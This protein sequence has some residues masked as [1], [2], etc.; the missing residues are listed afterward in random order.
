MKDIEFR[1]YDKKTKQ[2]VTEENVYKIIDDY[3]QNGKVEVFG[4]YYKYE[5][6]PTYNILVILRYLKEDI[7][8]EI[9]EDTN[10]PRFEIMQYTGLKDKNGK[11]IF[12]GDI[13][14]DFLGDVGV[15]VYSAKHSAFEVKGWENGYR[16]WHDIDIEVIGNIFDNK[17][18]LE[19]N[20][21]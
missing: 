19:A 16:F 18:I 8:D 14:K 15:V 17:E 6:Y 7:I 2:M 13:V 10:E 3:E 21:E 12:E 20:N 1:V 5:R 4:P 9:D 11:K